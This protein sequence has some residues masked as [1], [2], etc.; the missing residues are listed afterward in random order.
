MLD[1]A[2]GTVLGALRH[3]TPNTTPGFYDFT[4]Y[5]NS[6]GASC[7]ST[8][9]F[10]RPHQPSTSDTQLPLYSSARNCGVPA[11][12]VGFSTEE[13][14][15]LQSLFRDNGICLVSLLLDVTDACKGRFTHSMPCPCRSPAMPCR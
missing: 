13:M 6:L 14:L 15:L 5:S 9:G 4:Q 1:F 11:S 12:E 2:Q 10:V 8:G 3:S 7:I